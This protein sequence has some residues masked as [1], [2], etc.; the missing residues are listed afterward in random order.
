MR[1]LAEMTVASCPLTTRAC[2]SRLSVK[3]TLMWHCGKNGSDSAT[4][5]HGMSDNGRTDEKRRVTTMELI[6]WA[7]GETFMTMIVNEH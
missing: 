4:E 5:A 2:L 3:M 7:H 6:L 1:F